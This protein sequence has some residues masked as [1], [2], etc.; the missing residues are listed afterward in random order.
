MHRSKRGFGFPLIEVWG[1]T[2]MVS[3]LLDNVEPRSVGT[4]SFGRPVPGIEVRVVDEQDNDVATGTAGELIIR[5][6][7]TTPRLD[8][9][10]GY[11]DDDEATAQAWRNGWFHT[12]DT[13]RQDSDGTLHF[14]DRKKNIIRRSGENIADLLSRVGLLDGSALALLDITWAFKGPVSAGDTIHVR[15]TVSDARPSRKADRGVVRLAIEILNQ[16]NRTVQ[17]GQ[18]TVLVKKRQEERAGTSGG[19]V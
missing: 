3:V 16:L 13:I 8:F 5:H 15:A 18:A 4:R 11:L 19:R 9:F 6:S 17:T 14:V 1:M 10:S 2:E 7:Q 12:G